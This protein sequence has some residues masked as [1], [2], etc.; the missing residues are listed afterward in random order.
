MKKVGLKIVAI[1]HVVC[2]L[3][4]LYLLNGSFTGAF[5]SSVV[6]TLWYGVFPFLCLIAGVALLVNYKHAVRI[7][8]VVLALQIPHIFINGVTILRLGIAFNLY[9]TAMWNA[10][11]P[12]HGAT[13][14]GFDAL[15]VTMLVVLLTSRS[16]TKKPEPEQA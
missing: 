15:A 12:E 10:S 1:Y 9:L 4:G 11:S 13:V 3:G 6:P 16:A 5:P 8:I 14:L 2:A 7:S